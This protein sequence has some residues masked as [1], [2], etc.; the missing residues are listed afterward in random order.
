MHYITFFHNSVV[1]SA[2]LHAMQNALE[3]PVR[4]YKEVF[5][6]RCAMQNALEEPV[7]SYK[8][9]FSVRWLS[10]LDA[11]EAVI[12]TWPSLQNALEN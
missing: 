7:R 2:K 12:V 8:E 4:S 11:L 1:R 6:V 3:E 10:L 9:V 5:S